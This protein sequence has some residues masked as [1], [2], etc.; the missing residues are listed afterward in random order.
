MKSYSKF[1]ATKDV[2]PPRSA[3]A[4]M[5]SQHES[6]GERLR[7]LQLSA[8]SWAMLFSFLHPRH[9]IDRCVIDKLQNSPFL[10]SA[11]LPLGR[12]LLGK[13]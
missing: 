7:T 5:V 3:T 10:K 8:V 6:G 12:E 4:A 2:E 13:T 1:K 9:T 11:P